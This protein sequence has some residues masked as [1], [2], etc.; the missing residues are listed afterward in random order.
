MS[1]SLS[2]TTWEQTLLKQTLLVVTTQGLELGRL[3]GAALGGL[4]ALVQYPTVQV[5]I[6]R[7]DK[8]FS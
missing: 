2:T 3:R 1:I 7:S 6:G 4:S 8:S 5:H